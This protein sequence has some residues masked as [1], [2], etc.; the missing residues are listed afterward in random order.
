MAGEGMMSAPVREPDDGPTKDGPLNYAPKKVRHP[1]PDPN[2]AGA[3]RKGDLAPQSPAP[4]SPE[5]P[6]KRS[7]QRAVFAGDAAIAELRSKLALAPDRLPEPPP[8]PSTGPKYVLARRL[9]GVA[10]VTAV[11]VIGYQLGSAPPAS[12]PQ[13]APPPSQS[14]QQALASKR[15]VAYPPQAA[16]SAFASPAAANAI[17]LQSNEQK[18]R[19]AVS[20]RAVSGQLTVR[21][22]TLQ[23]ADEAA[24]LTVSAAD[25]GANAAVVI[26]GLAPGSVL[27]A[28]TQ[29]GPNTWR[30]AVEAL[31]GAAITPPRGFIGTM[32]LTLQLYLAD[33][34]VV[35][36]KGLQ[37]GWSG[38]SVVVPAKSQPRQHSAAEI[39]LMMKSGAAL[40]AN[41]DISG[42]Q[43]MYQRLAEEGK[44]MAALA[45]AETYDPLVLGKSNI[46]GGMTPDVTLAQS[47][48]EKA[49]S[50]GSTAARGRLER[51]ARLPE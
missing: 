38:K 19:D 32:D 2:S 7:K 39:A 1:E 37:L 26:S 44:A 6:W 33:N 31:T 34:T 21:A 20:S 40:L 36:R 9:A 14:N 25:A 46:S 24:R 41:G 3:P 51:L 35:D 12:P 8:P 29:V 49:T 10:G 22:V 13:L 5:P 17:V 4:E 30:L 45:L 27:S 18:S 15:S 28:G 43:L 11:G 16:E 47:W 48:Y 23:Q 42:A 50:L